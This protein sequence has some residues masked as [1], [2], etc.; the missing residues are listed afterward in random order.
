MQSTRQ[1]ATIIEEY[2][3]SLS[4]AD[5]LRIEAMIY[6]FR[7]SLTAAGE[8]GTLF[9][10]WVECRRIVRAHQQ[11]VNDNLITARRRGTD[12]M[13]PLVCISL[14]LTLFRLPG[15]AARL[16]S[17]V[18]WA[19][20]SWLCALVGLVGCCGFGLGLVCLVRWSLAALL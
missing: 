20:R 16:R 9:A 13:N 1:E 6:A 7:N 8:M 11:V 17:A 18:F 12:K 10:V 2:V 15:R 3:H 19:V 14:L 5:Y 4:W